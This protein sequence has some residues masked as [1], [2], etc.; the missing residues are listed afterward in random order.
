MSQPIRVLFDGGP[1]HGEHYAVLN[2]GEYVHVATTPQLSIDEDSDFENVGRITYSEVVY[3]DSGFTER[4]VPVYT[5]NGA[6]PIW[7][8]IATGG[9]NATANYTAATTGRIPIQSQKKKIDVKKLK[10]KTI[11]IGGS[12]RERG[13]K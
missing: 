8:R 4:G 6:Q 5:V 13:G 7:A 9:G 12:A 2:T 10:L 11:K 1:R 3:K